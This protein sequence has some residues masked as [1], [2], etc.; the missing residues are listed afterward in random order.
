MSGHVNGP[1]R[2]L[3]AMRVAAEM[4]VAFLQTVKTDGERAEPRVQQALVSF[5]CHRERVRNHA[6]GVASFHDFLAAFFEVCAH[7]GLAAG[8]HHDKVLWVNV[9]SQ[10][11][12]YPHK[13]F[14]RHVR[15]SFLHAIASAVQTMQVTTQGAFPEK[16]GERVSLDFVVAVKAIS[17]ESELLF[18]GDFHGFYSTLM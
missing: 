3:K 18:K 13:V 4:V 5:G 11:V 7:Q 15:D 17:F 10:L 14:A 12:E 1:Q 9:R 2:S 6:P 16:I 8:N